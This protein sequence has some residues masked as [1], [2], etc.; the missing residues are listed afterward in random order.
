M[1]IK[2]GGLFRKAILNRDGISASIPEVIVGITLK[3]AVTT[4]VAGA[5]L[6][7]FLFSS[8]ASAT[9]Q[10]SGATQAAELTFEEDA[11]GADGAV[12]LSDEG[13]AFF[14]A[15]SG[16]AECQ[17][18]LWQR[19]PADADGKVSLLTKETIESGPCDYTFPVDGLDGAK[20]AIDDAANLKFSFAN[21]GG[22]PIIFDENSG[23]SFGSGLQPAG[24]RGEEWTD[25]RVHTVEIEGG[26]NN[27]NLIDSAKT[28]TLAGKV[29]VAVFS[30]VSGAPGYVIPGVVVVKPTM[31]AIQ[32]VARSATVGTP[33]GTS[34]E[35]EGVKV[36]FTGGACLSGT[37]GYTLTY[38]PSNVGLDPVSLTGDIVTDGSTKSLEMPG[39]FNGST[40]EISLKLFCEPNGESVTATSAFTQTLPYPSGKLTWPGVT[41]NFGVPPTVTWNKVSSA[42]GVRYTLRLDQSM[43]YVPPG[44][45]L[46]TQWGGYELRGIDALSYKVE[47]PEG[48]VFGSTL[49]YS[50]SA[51]LDSVKSFGMGMMWTSGWPAAPQVPST[52]WTW[53]TD[54]YTAP[55]DG[56]ITWTA[57]TTSCPAG[58]ELYYRIWAPWDTAQ[59]GKY[60][61]ANPV[62]DLGWQ[63][64]VTFTTGVLRGVDN[65]VIYENSWFSWKTD[66]RC[67]NLYT[68]AFGPVTTNQGQFNNPHQPNYGAM[69]WDGSTTWKKTERP[70]ATQIFDICRNQGTVTCTKSA[71]G[72]SITVDVKNI[73][74]PANNDLTAKTARMTD[75]NGV[76]STV[77]LPVS[78][79]FETGGVSR[80]VKFSFFQFTCD[81]IH[82]GPTS[83]YG[84]PSWSKTITIAPLP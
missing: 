37:S 73:T 56:T 21:V 58:T 68:G 74:C 24:V 63:K 53:V 62:W 28:F 50:I 66:T 78:I 44:W 36:S 67:K 27:K 79:G 82:Y 48:S 10:V 81:P 19:G 18:N 47:F 9:S 75:W 34:S 72:D 25:V 54:A 33:Y 42:P 39:V 41:D 46:N 61:A 77:N 80:T 49:D 6:G 76:V 12:G 57:P 17:V 59:G 13:V 60:D 52:K 4:V 3:Y 43:G 29:P 1:T 20:P 11:R 69:T 7:L 15:T 14:R 32:S 5:L 83:G 2:S 16:G 22:R 65:H 70:V 64:D 84:N 71:Y 55:Y 51:Y 40:G 26:N 23:Q 45:E 31:V 8:A 35:R 38:T 30:L